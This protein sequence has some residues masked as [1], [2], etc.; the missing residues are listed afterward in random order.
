MFSGLLIAAALLFAPTHYVLAERLVID[1]EKSSD[2]RLV[3]CGLVGSG[4]FCDM[5]D[6]I[7]LVQNFLNFIWKAAWVLAAAMMIYG[8]FYMI[9][10]SFGAGGSGMFEKGKKILTNVA[11]GLVIVFFAWIMIDTIIKV[12]AGRDSLTS[13]V[14][15]TLPQVPDTPLTSVATQD[16]ES[17]QRVAKIQFGPWNKISCTRAP[18]RAPLALLEIPEALRC[19][20]KGPAQQLVGGFDRCATLIQQ[21]IQAMT[22]GQ[23]G[24]S[25][26]VPQGSDA[27]GAN[28]SNGM[29]SQYKD[30]ILKYASD[31]QIDP[32]HFQSL[33]MLESSGRMDNPGQ[34]G[35]IGLT[36]MFPSVAIGIVPELKGKTEAF[37]TQWLKNS[38]NNIKAGAIL[39]RQ[40]LNYPGVN[41]NLVLA[42]AMYNGG[43]PAIE[44]STRCPGQLAFQCE[45]NPGFAPTRNS[46]RVID[47][48]IQAIQS[49]QCKPL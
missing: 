9:L 1:I 38:D 47:A 45:K 46:R 2:P 36:Q 22:N 11:W 7:V 30:S 3:T 18:D 20:P 28:C 48:N 37:A 24:E 29:L 41:G 33:I 32:T 40:N 23:E 39:L 43:P 34:K 35:E 21:N 15:A 5:C 12:I 31:Y 16:E 17:V 4:Q 19:D 42:E 26:S 13:G 27:Q 14:P 6:L 25:L 44:K 8:G 10:P 49:S